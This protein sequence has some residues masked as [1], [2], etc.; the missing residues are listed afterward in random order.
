MA[1]IDALL[2]RMGALDASDLHLKSGEAP[3]FRI[4]GDLERYDARGVVAPAE[5]DAYVREILRPEQARRLDATGEL[6]FGYG[7]VR[8]GRYRVNAFRD[9]SGPAAAFRR[10]P[11][12]VP[13]I[14]DLA[15]PDS[16]EHFA[17][18]RSGLVLFTGAT[19]SGKTSTMASLLDVINSQHRRHIVTLEDPIEFL[20][21]PKK[22]LVRQRG[23]H[24][25][26]PD[27]ATGI[28]NAL[29]EDVEVLLLGEMRDLESI[30]LAL[31]A[32]EVGVLVFATLHTN[33]A[34]ASC[35]RIV[36]VFSAEEQPQIRAMLSQSLAG[37]VSQVLLRRIDGRG[38]IPAVEV[39]HATPAVG[40]MIRENKVQEIAN[41]IQTGKAAGMQTMDDALEALV[42][43]KRVDPREA[44]A[45]ATNRVRFEKYL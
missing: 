5:V 8:R 15:L 3:R 17:H 36:D 10:I 32:G 26:V 38:R 31:T 19:G 4:R 22:S 14:R 13:S 16:V 27:F 42:A 37:I 39:L 33:G 23:V 1:Q 40:S 20:H 35:D 24:E 30:R 6:D 9:L 25:D 7:D 28:R 11:G 12:V 43:A 41:V 34:A 2:E 18:L 21:E 44:W 45:Y 29:R